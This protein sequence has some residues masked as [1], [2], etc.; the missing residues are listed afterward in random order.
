MSSKFC[1]H[2]S[3]RPKSGKA[4]GVMAFQFGRFAKELEGVG[5]DALGRNEAW[6]NN[7]R[8]A[9]TRPTSA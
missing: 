2:I 8:K 5:I 9:W 3:K 6:L 7:S 4:I 1:A